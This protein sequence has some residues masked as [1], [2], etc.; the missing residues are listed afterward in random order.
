MTNNS[1]SFDTSEVLSDFFS[2][3]TSENIQFD[4][5]QIK[6]PFK[7]EKN[8]TQNATQKTT[9]PTIKQ[10][11]TAIATT[12]DN[13]LS[14][15]TTNLD[16]SMKEFDH[17][18]GRCHDTNDTRNKLIIRNRHY[19]KYMKLY[20]DEMKRENQNQNKDQRYIDE[21]T[22]L[23]EEYRK[24]NVKY[25]DLI[26]YYGLV[27][28]ECDRQEKKIADKKIVSDNKMA[29]KKIIE[30]KKMAEKKIS[31]EKKQ[32]KNKTSKAEFDDSS[33]ENKIKHMT[34]EDM[35]DEYY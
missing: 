12:I 9:N 8:A 22:K 31:E 2:D 4:N 30:E 6:N 34:I 27:L 10:K 29:E 25:V 32:N 35:I 24:K 19:E 15:I 14:A 28:T 26:N 3:S 20:Y 21:L 7:S 5:S 1:T 11:I 33:L 17:D 23:N 16:E 13:K 18:T